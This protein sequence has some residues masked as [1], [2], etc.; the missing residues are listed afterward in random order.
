MV[1]VLVL[2]MGHVPILISI[3]SYQSLPIDIRCNLPGVG[4]A[5]GQ[6]EKIYWCRCDYFHGVTFKSWFC[7]PESSDARYLRWSRNESK[8]GERYYVVLLFCKINENNNSQRK[9]DRLNINH[10]IR[11][12]LI[13][14]CLTTIAFTSALSIAWWYI[15]LIRTVS[16]KMS[17]T[18]KITVY[19]KKKHLNC[20]IDY[21]H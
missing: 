13:G 4:V 1:L 10:H 5:I 14:I 2:I 12:F 17:E 9:I 21:V 6:C 11:H 19:F 8:S 20:G 18:V 16:E 15:E 7:F 3:P